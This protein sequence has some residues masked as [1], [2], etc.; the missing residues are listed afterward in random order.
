MKG[1]NSIKNIVLLDR[2]VKESDYRT[3]QRSIERV[4]ELENYEW[5]TLRI[6]ED[7]GIKVE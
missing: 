7:G 1:P 6:K 4:V 2:E 5:Q 3:V